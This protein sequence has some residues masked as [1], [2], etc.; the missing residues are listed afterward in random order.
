VPLPSRSAVVPAMS[1]G[2][3]EF[4][5]LDR[6]R[7]ILGYYCLAGRKRERAIDE[8]QGTVVWRGLGE[9]FHGVK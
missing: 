6:K 9:I 1:G 5:P 2:E 4:A 3:K 7:E 8:F